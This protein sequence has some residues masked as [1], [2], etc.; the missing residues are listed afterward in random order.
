MI[1]EA[2][3]TQRKGPFSQAMR[4]L[5]SRLGAHLVDL[6]NI[7]TVAAS[8]YKLSGWFL[9]SWPISRMGKSNVFEFV[10]EYHHL[11]STYHQ[12]EGEAPC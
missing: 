12:G 1:V 6:T 9:L 2:Y 3:L 5:G 4:F 8:L 11:T 7:T 10:R